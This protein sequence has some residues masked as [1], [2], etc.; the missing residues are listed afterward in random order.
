M[1]CVDLYNNGVVALVKTE[2]AVLVDGILRLK[3]IF[4][5]ILFGVLISSFVSIMYLMDVF[6]DDCPS[7]VGLIR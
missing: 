6:R 7:P 4:H 1:Q 3:V 2:D 5:P